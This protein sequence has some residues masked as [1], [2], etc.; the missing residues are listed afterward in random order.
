MQEQY[1]DRVEIIG[2]A[3]RDDLSAMEAF[4]SDLGVGAFP[5][6]ANEDLDIWS[7]YEVRSQ[8]AFVFI[9]DDGS[10]QTIIGAMGES[11][12]TSMIDE[13]LAT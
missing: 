12:L 13:L 9:N 8:P 3:G 5:H 1:A 11:G 2:V 4:V 6:V 7:S 10:Y